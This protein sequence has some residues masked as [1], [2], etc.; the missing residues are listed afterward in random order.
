MTDSPPA[1]P[2]ASAVTVTGLRCA[3]CGATVDIATPWP[4]RCPSAGENRHHVLRIQRALAPLRPSADANPFLAFDAEFAWAAFADA[5]GLDVAA[6][7]SLVASVDAD[8]A[9][10]DGRGF[11]VTPLARADALSD[12]LGFSAEGGVFVKDETHNVS[13]SHKARHLVTILLHLLAAEQVGLRSATARPP[14]AIA[15]C[16]NAALAAATLAAAVRWPLQ[17]FV[18]PSA[19]PAV[20]ARLGALGAQ[21]VTCPRLATDPPGDPCVHRFRE[22][23]AAGAVPFGVQ[24][25]ENAL[26]LDGG[27]TMGFELY[28][29]LGHLIDRVFVQVGGGALVTGVGDGL[30]IGGVHPRIHAVQTEGCAPLARAW[31]G[32]G[33][34]GPA[35]A[36]GRWAELMWPW[37]H[38][39]LSAAHGILDDETYDWLGAVDAMRGGGGGPI[40][41]P[42][43]DVLR[44]NDL[45]RAHTDIDADHTGTAGL[46]GVLTARP[47]I[48]DDER[49]V[50]IFSG[51]RRS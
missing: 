49:V 26:C 21:I 36:A 2:A 28:E 1:A 35:G 22:A 17:V 41:S 29:G 42:E 14:L 8:V 4:W 40:V 25:P 3:S 47:E 43:A 11:V 44:A 6:R 32:L 34:G 20:L 39:P 48:G 24:G 23:V 9:A 38:E 10:V 16:G 31:G 30:R 27:R 45:A 37:E 7:R 5:H 51:I 18:P 15:S 33:A 19:N 13:G 12:A 50:V 46:A